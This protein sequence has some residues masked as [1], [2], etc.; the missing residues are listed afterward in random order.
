MGPVTA[1]VVLGGSDWCQLYLLFQVTILPVC[2]EGQT[3]GICVCGCRCEGCWADGC[4]WV[5]SL[6]WCCQMTL[7]G[8]NHLVGLMVR[9]PPRE[10]KIPGSNPACAGIFFGVESYQ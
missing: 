2:R 6:Q 1:V 5:L 9:C 8:V 7:N 3:K 10:R 4:G